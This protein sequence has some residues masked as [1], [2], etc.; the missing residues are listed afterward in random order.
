MDKRCD[1]CKWWVKKY[2]TEIYGYCDPP[3]P[4]WEAQESVYITNAKSGRNCFVWQPKE[5]RYD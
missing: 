1:T 5:M 2:A 3:R 4:Y